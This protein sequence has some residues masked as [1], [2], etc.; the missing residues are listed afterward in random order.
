M[1]SM[2]KL[3]ATAPRSFVS[4]ASGC[5]LPVSA[6]RSISLMLCVIRGRACRPDS[7]CART[8]DAADKMA[9]TAREKD[10]HLQ[11]MGPLSYA[12]ICPKP[13]AKR[14]KPLEKD[15]ALALALSQGHSAA[16]M[17]DNCGID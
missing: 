5:V 13:I 2:A 3:L 12:S 9:R 10:P 6:T 8:V 7:T 1:W 14:S 11:T 17:P 15:H 4:L 16:S